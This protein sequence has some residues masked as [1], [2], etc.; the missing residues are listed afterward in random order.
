MAALEPSFWTKKNLALTGEDEERISAVAN[1][2]ASQEV[3]VAGQEG[4]QYSSHRA[5][6]ESEKEQDPY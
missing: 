6:E 5:G 4:V 3:E 2:V 1:E